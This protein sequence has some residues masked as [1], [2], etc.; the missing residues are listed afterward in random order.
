M[1]FIVVDAATVEIY[2]IADSD[3]VRCIITAGLDG[4]RCRSFAGPFPE[5]LPEAP[6]GQ[7]QVTVA[8]AMMACLEDQLGALR[9]Q[10]LDTARHMKDARVLVDQVYGVGPVPRSR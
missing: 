2:G 5:R 9:D 4:A 10:L 7:Q 8:L 1:P 3:R 6:A